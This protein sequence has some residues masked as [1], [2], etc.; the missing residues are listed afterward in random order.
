M[1]A[2][3]REVATGRAAR[4]PV[5]Q[6]ALVALAVLAL[7]WSWQR[8][9]LVQQQVAQPG[10]REPYITDLILPLDVGTLAQQV[11]GAP[12]GLAPPPRSPPRLLVRLSR[13]TYQLPPAAAAA[14][15]AGGAL[16]GRA[17]RRMRC[18]RASHACCRACSAATAPT[19]RSPPRP[20]P[21]P[22]AEA[23]AW[24]STKT[25]LSW[26][27]TPE[28]LRS[29]RVAIVVDPV[30]RHQVG[31][32][33][34][35]SRAALAALLCGTAV[36]HG[37]RCAS[38]RCA[39]ISAA[40]AA[41]SSRRSCSRAPEP[42]HRAAPGSGADEPGRPPSGA[43]SGGDRSNTLPSP[44]PHIYTLPLPQEYV[45]ADALAKC[46]DAIVSHCKDLA[47]TGCFGGWSGKLDEVRLLLRACV[48]V[49]TSCGNN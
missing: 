17:H 15:G 43:R 6:L 18:C 32:R 27:P 20:P 41:A 40:L 10:P 28:Q 11:R 38:V 34:W 7:G 12:R 4:M 16:P 46:L 13:A 5:V 22:Q 47:K 24:C 8:P 44:Y 31:A 25:Q 33:C 23:D 26:P 39:L 21:C 49:G 14:V 42:C 2:A 9:A 48:V 29:L 37:S 45:S 3:Q 1:K 36:W 19:G 35:F 30:C